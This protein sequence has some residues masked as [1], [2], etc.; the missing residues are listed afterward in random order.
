MA[1]QCPRA[2]ACGA[3]QLNGVKYSTQLSRKQAYVE[4]LLSCFGPVAPILGMEN[5]FHYRNKVQSVFGLNSK[6]EVING[7]YRLGTHKL[8]PI[9]DC[10]IE[11]EEADSI[12]ETIKAL[13]KARGI[14]PYDED[15][16]V[17]AIRHVLIRRAVST[18]QS[19]VV[20]VSGS[21]KFRPKESFAQEI[22]RRHP[23]VKGVLLN[24]NAEKTSMVLSDAPCKLIWGRGWIED[25]LCGLRFRISAKS[26]YQ[27][28]AVQAAKLYT[29][30]M[31]MAR[32]SG[33]ETV[34][35][36]YCGTGTIGLISSR[37]GAGRVI[38][39]ELNESAVAD[40]IENASING[41]SNATF[42]CGD[43][44]AILK[45]MAKGH[46]WLGQDGALVGIDPENKAGYTQI[47][48]A[49]VL[50]M[51]P[52]RSGS[53][54]RFLSSVI[55]ISPKTIVYISCN[56]QTLAR[57][58]RYLTINGPYRMV[59]AQPVDLFPQTEH[60]EVVALLTLT[61]N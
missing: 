10:M 21:P 39:I 37:W 38:G 45:D 33:K 61:T 34:I 15:R 32:F 19:L 16:Q 42:L 44:S 36:A 30:A 4:S 1:K 9:R 6:G 25:E 29:I 60:V 17:G 46:V 12:L 55:K 40:A 8:I 54:E 43:A 59:G 58:L 26:F 13:V 5:P 52:P 48:K 50:F 56:P 18:N 27:V 23:S 31:R 22:A 20:I 11:D 35:D 51:D 3:C 14:E 24:V 47:S 49:D 41:I 53:D 57:D 28:N 2:G 7:I